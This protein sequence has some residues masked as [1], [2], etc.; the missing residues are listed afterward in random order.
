M[1]VSLQTHCRVDRRYIGLV[2]H[3]YPYHYSF[4][5]WSE[6]DDGSGNACGYEAGDD[7]SSWYRA[8]SECNRANAAYSLYGILKGERD[9]GCNKHTYINSFF[10][11]TG[12]ET[13]M[14]Y[15][16]YAGES[17]SDGNAG[18]DD[19]GNDG[20]SSECTAEQNDD[21]YAR[22]SSSAV[23]CMDGRYVEKEFSGQYC[24]ETGSSFVTDELSTFNSEMNQISCKAIYTGGQN[25]NEGESALDLLLYSETCDIREYP[26][27]CPDPYKK[28]VSYSNKLEDSTE[29]VHSSKKEKLRSVV[30]WMLLII[31]VLLIISALMSMNKSTKTT[32]DLAAQRK[33]NLWQRIKM[34]FGR[35]FLRR[36]G[37]GGSK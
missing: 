6:Y 7:E 24:K 20:F 34:A 1:R 14:T 12:V 27:T 8:L 10:T 37:R 32:E 29:F 2:S 30:S 13:F 4:F 31:G 15:M 9:T 35:V 28:L 22:S 26:N 18:G 3:S 11:K 16:E 21:A 19:G 25:N 36:K 23:A 33:P 5:S 17:F